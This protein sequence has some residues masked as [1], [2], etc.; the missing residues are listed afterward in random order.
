MHGRDG[1]QGIKGGPARTARLYI[2]TDASMGPIR[3]WLGDAL[4]WHG[5]AYRTEH[6]HNIYLNARF[7]RKAII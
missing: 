4:S 2:K 6:P 5:V 7:K 3:G 1:R